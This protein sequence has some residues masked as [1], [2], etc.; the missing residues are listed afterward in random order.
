[1]TNICLC[2]RPSQPSGVMHR[3]MESEWMSLRYGAVAHIPIMSYV[4]YLPYPAMQC[5]V[6]PVNNQQ[7]PVKFTVNALVAR[8]QYRTV[9]YA[10]FFFT[11]RF[12]PVSAKSQRSA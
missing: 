11:M 12:S 3:R 4:T 1:M 7:A 2:L 6:I 9:K 10:G 5:V 8:C